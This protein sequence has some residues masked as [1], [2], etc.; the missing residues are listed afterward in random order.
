MEINDIFLHKSP[1]NRWFRN[2]IHSW[3]SRSDARVNADI[4]YRV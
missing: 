2:G 4:I 3:L 1:S